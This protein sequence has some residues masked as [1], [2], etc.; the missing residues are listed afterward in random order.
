MSKFT[1][2]TFIH[3]EVA[4]TKRLLFLFFTLIV[5]V[6][7]VLSQSTEVRKQVNVPYVDPT[8]IT[9]DGVMNEAAWN[10]AASANMVTNA[11]FEIFAN[12][13]YREAIPEPEYDEMVGRMLW[14]KDTLYV[15]MHI[16]EFVNDSTDLFW[17][18]KFNGDQLFISLSN[19]LGVEMKGW[20]DGNVYAAPDGPY[21]FWVLGDQ[22]SLNNGDTTYIPDEYMRFADDTTRV[23]NAADIARWGITIDKTT[24]V[25]DV[26]M[27]IYNPHVN[28]QSCIGFNLGG[29]TGSTYSDTAF[30]DAY[31]YYTWQPSVIDSPFAVPNVPMPDWGPDPGYFN[32][33]TS[34]FWAILNFVD[35]T[36]LSVK[37]RPIGEGIPQVYSLAQNYPNPFNPSTMIQFALPRAGKVDLKVYN[38]LG[39]AVATLV[40]GP[41][42]AG[43][44]EAQWNASHLSSGLYF[45]RLTVDNNVVDTRKMVLVK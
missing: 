42:A 6:S 25:W 32:L 14:A 17:N 29:S 7:L 21:H 43:R 24:G 8:A 41:M 19:R 11:G 33:A 12:K 37:E 2:F 40:N 31:G 45:Y 38:I 44:Y 39:Q 34:N 13:Y 18:G 16:D 5:S 36:T 23:F 15:F 22:V 26:E 20:Y 9:I 3:G 35:Q 27:A 4:M 30:G 28:A 10:N 1:K